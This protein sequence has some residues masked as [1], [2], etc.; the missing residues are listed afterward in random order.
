[1]WADAEIDRRVETVHRAAAAAGR[2]PQLEVLVQAIEITEAADVAAS[3]LA[4]SVP[5][6]QRI[7]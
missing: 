1:M 7:K 6:S 3:R 2:T 4:V 5:N